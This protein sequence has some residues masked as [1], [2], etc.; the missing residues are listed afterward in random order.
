MKSRPD[1]R[2]AALA[3]ARDRRR[4]ASL[5][6]AWIEMVLVSSFFITL[7]YDLPNA[8]GR[9]IKTG[10]L[11]VSCVVHLTLAF[12]LL[13]ALREVSEWPACNSCCCSEY[14]D[15]RRRSSDI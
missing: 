1:R 3:E 6:V 14:N 5:V 7:L 10:A 11:M 4:R 15:S 13:H 2:R 9:L 12:L 8:D